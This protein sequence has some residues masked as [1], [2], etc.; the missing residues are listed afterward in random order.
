[1]IVG[2]GEAAVLEIPHSIRIKKMF[3]STY[4]IHQ[5]HYIDLLKKKYSILILQHLFWHTFHTWK[6][7]PHSQLVSSVTQNQ[8]KM[9]K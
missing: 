8:K 1:M 7:L 5:L 9:W 2:N 3:N 4:I 6:T